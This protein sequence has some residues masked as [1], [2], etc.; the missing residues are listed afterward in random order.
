MDSAQVQSKG[1]SPSLWRETPLII[2]AIDVGGA[3]ATFRMSDEYKKPVRMICMIQGFSLLRYARAFEWR[4]KRKQAR[5]IP[6][7]RMARQW[8]NCK[9][10]TLHYRIRHLL[11]MFYMDKWTRRCPHSSTENLRIVWFPCARDWAFKPLDSVPYLP[12]YV[13]EESF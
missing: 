10:G 11:S 7:P 2:C 4:A 1:A 13:D 5:R 9:G 3:K 6:L 8:R 12:P